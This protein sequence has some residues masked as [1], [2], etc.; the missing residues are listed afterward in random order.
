MTSSIEQSNE[1]LIWSEADQQ[2]AIIFEEATYT[3]QTL[4]S[5]IN[6]ELSTIQL[7]INNLV[8][9][10]EQQ[11]NDPVNDPNNISKDIKSKLNKKRG[12][13]KVE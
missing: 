13:D 8:A 5:E 1:I 7:R 10:L 6:T 2:R 12:F 3:Q 4:I 9:Q 11:V